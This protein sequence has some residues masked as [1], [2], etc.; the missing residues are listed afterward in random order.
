[1]TCGSAEDQVWPG[2]LNP[3][4]PFKYREF[5]YRETYMGELF[6]IMALIIQGETGNSRSVS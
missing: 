4:L 2:V 5:K 3:R 6:T 1:M